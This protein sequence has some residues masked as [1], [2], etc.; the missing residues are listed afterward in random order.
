M[1]AQQ[2]IFMAPGKAWAA[3][4]SSPPSMKNW[5]AYCQ[6]DSFLQLKT[7]SWGGFF[8]FGLVFCCWLKLQEAVY[9][10]C[11]FLLGKLGSQ[12]CSELHFYHLEKLHCPV[13]RCSARADDQQLK[14]RMS[15]LGQPGALKKI[16]FSDFKLSQKMM[17]KGPTET[18]NPKFL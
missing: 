5:P 14:I 6:N 2:W 7:E 15:A 8:Y 1:F 11:E 13:S 17:A 10:G 4:T 18:P 3:F 12:L 9:W 16:F